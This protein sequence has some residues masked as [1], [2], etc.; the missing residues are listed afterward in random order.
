[1]NTGNDSLCYYLLIIQVKRT[2]NKKTMGASIHT[3]SHDH[4]S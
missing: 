4:N 1:M 3:N 2:K